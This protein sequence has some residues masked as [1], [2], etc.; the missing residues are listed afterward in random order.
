M[1]IVIQ[2]QNNNEEAAELKPGDTLLVKNVIKIAENS[3]ELPMDSVCMLEVSPLSSTPP[4]SGTKPG[5]SVDSGK[6]GELI[7]DIVRQILRYTKQVEKDSRR[8]R[9]ARGIAEAKANGVKFGRKP[10]VQPELL[11]PIRERWQ[12]GEISAKDAAKELGIGIS[13]FYAWVGKG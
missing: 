10:K 13:S 9:Q 1:V 3:E 2:S 11:E 8:R 7:N 5:L 12:R 6:T 4:A